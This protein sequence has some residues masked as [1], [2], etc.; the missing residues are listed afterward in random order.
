MQLSN[1][2]NTKIEVQN[3]TPSSQGSL[4]TP[5]SIVVDQVNTHLSSQMIS[6]YIS[7]QSDL[8]MNEAKDAMIGKIT[9]TDSANSSQFLLLSI[10]VLV[11]KEPL[12]FE[13]NKNLYEDIVAP[14]T[15]AILAIMFPLINGE[16]APIVGMSPNYNCISN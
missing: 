8:K 15:V 13:P 9:V 3:N 7:S 5:L 6:Y 12:V 14:L 4:P 2:Y 10:K 1:Q 11:Q 16:N